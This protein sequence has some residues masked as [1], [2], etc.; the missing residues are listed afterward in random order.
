MQAFEHTM[1]CDTE[2][3][4]PVGSS[5]FGAEPPQAATF[6]DS[7]PVKAAF[8]TAVGPRESSQS[9]PTP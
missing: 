5:E 2:G 7:I 8:P 4:G 6:S 1:E 9:L 3:T